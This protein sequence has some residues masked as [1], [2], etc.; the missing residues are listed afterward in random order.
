MKGCLEKKPWVSLN[1]MSNSPFLCKGVKKSKNLL[2][3]S[4]SLSNVTWGPF[5]CTPS[6]EVFQILTGLYII[7]LTNFCYIHYSIC[8][9]L[10][11]QNGNFTSRSVFTWT[12]CIKTLLNSF[13]LYFNFLILYHLDRLS[14]DK[15]KWLQH[16]SYKEEAQK[17]FF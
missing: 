11:T 5:P 16:I 13:S 4:C 12:T 8:S 17:K 14:I 9:I 6:F 10:Y 15:N 3:E 2:G 7:T 1:P